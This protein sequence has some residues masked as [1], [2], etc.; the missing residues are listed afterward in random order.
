MVLAAREADDQALGCDWLVPTSEP[1]TQTTPT[2]RFPEHR[3]RPTHQRKSI[4]PQRKS[5]ALNAVSQ[6]AVLLAGANK[7]RG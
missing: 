3:P 6:H 4:Q 7:K 2:K 1:Q 5:R